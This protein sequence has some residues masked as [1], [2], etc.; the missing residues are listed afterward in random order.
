M[1]VP[2]VLRVMIVQVR[3]SSERSQSHCTSQPAG[4]QSSSV[5][6]ASAAVP[7]RRL[8][9][10]LTATVPGSSMSV[11]VTV[12]EARPESCPSKA[13]MSTRS[14]LTV[15]WSS[16]PAT[17]RRPVLGF[18]ARGTSPSRLYAKRS[19]S[20]SVAVIAQLGTAP[21]A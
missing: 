18:T 8:P 20:A 12:S 13:T 17:L 3:P 21:L 1:W 6:A 5:R 9:P 11:T 19:L 2:S 16:G 15:S 7:T 14:S 4:T 10:R